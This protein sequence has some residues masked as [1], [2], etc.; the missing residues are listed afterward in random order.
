MRRN[1]SQTAKRRSHHAISG[2]RLA[3]CECGALRVA[4]RACA[5]CGTYNGRVVIDIVARAKRQTRRDKRKQTE[6]RESG[7]ATETRE[8]E[9]SVPTGRQEPA[10]T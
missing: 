2:E 10:Q 7:Q 9:K 5:N 3:T 8:K 1:R 6:L 4:H